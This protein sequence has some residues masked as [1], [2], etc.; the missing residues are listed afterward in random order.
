MTVKV[1]PIIIAL[2]GTKPKKIGK[3]IDWLHKRAISILAKIL[4]KVLGI[5]GVSLALSLK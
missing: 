3:K 4:R 5:W 2:L 1:V